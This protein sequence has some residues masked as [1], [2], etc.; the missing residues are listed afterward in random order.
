MGRKSAHSGESPKDRSVNLMD[1][2]ITKNANR[3]K[4]QP[5]LPNLSHFQQEMNK[6]NEM[7]KK[8]HKK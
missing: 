7:L 6:I 5:K 2:F 4:N 3:E 8:N 1:K